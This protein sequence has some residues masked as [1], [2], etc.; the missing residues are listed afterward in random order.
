MDQE[1]SEIPESPLDV[2]ALLRKIETGW[3]PR[4]LCFWGHRAKAGQVAAGLHLLSQWWESE[5]EAGGIR[6]ATAEHYMMAEKARLF[7]DDETCARILAAP[8]PGAA[9]ALGREVKNFVEAEWEAHRFDIVV[10]GNAGKFAQNAELRTYLLHTGEKVIVEASPV[11]LIWGAG[12][13]AGDPLVESPDRWPG[14]NLLGFALM[15]VR[16]ILRGEVA[17]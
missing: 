4:Y 7:G 3:R 8:S 6:Y 9:K 14:A 5:F 1:P 12:V 17:G 2:A 10:R 11:D 15:K 13:A 16:A